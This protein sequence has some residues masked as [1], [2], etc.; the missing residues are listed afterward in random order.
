MRE[1]KDNNRDD[2]NESEDRIVC[3]LRNLTNAFGPSSFEVD[4]RKIFTEEVRDFSDKIWTCG[5][6]SII[7]QKKGTSDSPRIMIAGHMDEVGFMVK[8]I[9]KKGFLRV[10]PIG[11][12][13]GHVLPGKRVLIR[14]R[15]GKEIVGIVGA[16]APHK[17][18][19]DERKKV[20]ELEDLFVDVG[21][22]GKYNAAE[23]MGIKPGD[24][25][26]PLTDF[27]VLGDGK[28]LSAKAW[29]NRIGVATAIEVLK[30]LKDID[31]PNTVF[32]VGTVQEEVGLRG[33][34][35][36]AF[37]VNPDIGF[38]VDVTIAADTPGW[39][40]ELDEDVGIGPSISIMD[41]SLLP[42]HKLRDFAIET[43]EEN[44]IPYQIGS[45]TRGGTDGGAIARAR[46]G[47]PT[48]TLSV[49]TRYIH[50]HN[51][52]LHLDDFKNLTK[53]L[54]EIIKKLDK[55]TVDKIRND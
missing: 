32:S 22:Y 35:T 52:I 48:L 16:K 3:L 6:G 40:S 44:D 50:S 49:A 5:L 15:E 45:L 28:M 33:A 24:P 19:P 23:E 12:W 34:T 4:V 39:E 18:K 30:E 8:G 13:W 9:T 42:N 25:I 36:S 27:H 21:S 47:V 2:Y 29:D 54:T 26:V 11:G 51:G 43:A 1:P 31:H 41:G 55:N 46:S 37:E 10:N 7:A 20:I 53:L 17:L 14:T 38:A